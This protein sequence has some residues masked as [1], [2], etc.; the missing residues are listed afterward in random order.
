MDN[1]W[2][3]IKKGLRDGAALSMEKIEEY[4]KLGKLKVEE[5][6]AKRKIE[7]NFMDLGERAFDLIEEGKGSEIAQDLTVRKSI[8]NVN[9]LREELKELDLKMREVTESAKKEHE[10]EDSDISDV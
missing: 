5:M 7:R 1:M 6:A 2:E 10:E 3:K 8:E 4:T 9:A